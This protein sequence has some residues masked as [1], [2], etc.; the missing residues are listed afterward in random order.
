MEMRIAN[1]RGHEHLK[2]V[3]RGIYMKMAYCARGGYSIRAKGD[4]R[5]INRKHKN[6]F[7][8]Q[9]ELVE[10]GKHIGENWVARCKEET[11][12]VEK[13]EWQIGGLSSSIGF[14][15]PQVDKWAASYRGLSSP[16]RQGG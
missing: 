12:K 10:I 8:L 11:G 14:Y 6:C 3:H 13:S 4:G 16:S 9:K 2:V 15:M 7:P 5:S 1:G